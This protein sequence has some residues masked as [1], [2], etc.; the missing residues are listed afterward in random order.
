MATCLIG[1]LVRDLCDELVISLVSEYV[2]TVIEESRLDR[3]PVTIRL[4]INLLMI[5]S[6]YFTSWRQPLHSIYNCPGWR[7]T[8]NTW[9][10][11][12]RLWDEGLVTRTIDRGFK[13]YVTKDFS[14]FVIGTLLIKRFSVETNKRIEIQRCWE[15][16][17]LLLFKMLIQIEKALSKY[18]FVIW[19]LYHATGN[20]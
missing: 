16:S 5:W 13:V 11:R 15:T 14:K 1:G 10:G 3:K 12:I 9:S 7:S 8:N 2:A 20:W 4:M 17:L 19:R 18:I 6:C